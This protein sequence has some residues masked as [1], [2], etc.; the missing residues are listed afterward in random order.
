VTYYQQAY[1]IRD[2]LK[3]TDG[4]AESL[5]N[6]AEANV[7]LG[8]YG[9]AVNQFL[10]ALDISRNGGDMDGVALNSVSQGMLYSGLCRCGRGCTLRP[11]A[12]RDERRYEVRRSAALGSDVPVN[13]SKIV[14]PLFVPMGSAFK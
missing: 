12:S 13:D 9:T 10:K 11:R 6:L 5:H 2:K 1:E 14:I 8:Q 3:L 7:A 4:V